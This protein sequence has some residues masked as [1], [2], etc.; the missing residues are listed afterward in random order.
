MNSLVYDT[1][2]IGAGA[3]GLMAAITCGRHGLRGV[4]LDAS[5]KCGAKIRMSGGGRCNITHRTVSEKDYAGENPRAVRDVL[6]AF[7]SSKTIAFFKDAGVEL[8]C[9]DDGKLF[10]STHSGRIVCDE[11][12]EQ[13]R[14][15]GIEIETGLKV[16]GVDSRDGFFLISGQ[17]FHRLGRTVVICTG[18]MSY[19]ETGSDGSGFALAASLGHRIIAPI[20][21]LTPLLT[22]DGALKGLAGISLPC[23]L[24]L[25]A[26]NRRIASFEAP[27]LFTHFGFS[28][29]C[30]LDISRFWIRGRSEGPAVLEADFLPQEREEGFRK[31]FLDAVRAYPDRQVKTFLGERLPERLAR[32]IL[33]KQGV[34]EDLVLNQVN[35]LARE[36]LIHALF[37]F[38]LP[39]TGAAG[40]DKA[41]VTAGGVDLSEIDP[42]T[43]ES[44]IRPGLFFAG[45][46]LDA[47][48]RIGGFNFQWAWA[49]GFVAAAGVARRLAGT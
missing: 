11:L 43:M 38:P 20:P 2:I 28:G 8:V 47:D 41:E 13:T 36:A 7:P 9:E 44:R 22:D 18:G 33:A 49:S 34:A 19:P 4:L 12:I 10:P 31:S 48:G 15:S 5:S 3:S 27:F 40:Y 23:R 26:G 39:V 25:R 37:H 1:V 46:V 29:P 35:R 45:E 24:S 14:R 17:G 6:R 32:V 42:G 30:V 21:A 16:G